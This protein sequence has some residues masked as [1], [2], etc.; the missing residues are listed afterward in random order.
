M[1]YLICFCLSF[2]IGGDFLGPK[3]YSCSFVGS[4]VKEITVPYG[5]T[6]NITFWVL[7]TILVSTFTEVG[8]ALQF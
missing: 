2:M 5:Q 8:A 4:V 6:I 7:N 3:S 1:V